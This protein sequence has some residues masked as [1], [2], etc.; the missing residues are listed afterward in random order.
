M[1]RRNFEEK[2]A[3]AVLAELS[4]VEGVVFHQA[5]KRAARELGFDGGGADVTVVAG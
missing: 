1:G 2:N 3:S 4:A 5:V